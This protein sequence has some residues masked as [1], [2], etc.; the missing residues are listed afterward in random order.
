MGTYF[1][2]RSWHWPFDAALSATDVP[3]AG[4]E[5]HR[6][7]KSVPPRFIVTTRIGSCVGSPATSF[8]VRSVIDLPTVEEW[9]S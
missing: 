1:A 5:S 7:T 4:V 2:A 6:G 8:P 9:P 3:I